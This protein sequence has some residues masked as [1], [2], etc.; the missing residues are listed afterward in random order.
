MAYHCLVL[1]CRNNARVLGTLSLANTTCSPATVSAEGAQFNGRPFPATAWAEGPQLNA[2]PSPSPNWRGN[3]RAQH[4][5]EFEEFH[6][7]AGP[8]ALFVSLGHIGVDLVNKAAA[9]GPF[10]LNVGKVGSKH[11]AIYPHMLPFLHRHSLV[12]H[13]KVNVLPDIRAG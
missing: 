6:R 10:A 3:C 2:A 13:T 8:D 12:L 5:G 11:N 9:V 4:L 1:C 7:V